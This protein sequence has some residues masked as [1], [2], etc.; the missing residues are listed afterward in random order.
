MPCRWSSE[1]ASEFYGTALARFA[2]RPVGRG[3]QVL[4]RRLDREEGE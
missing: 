2:A 4:L 1:A 3:E